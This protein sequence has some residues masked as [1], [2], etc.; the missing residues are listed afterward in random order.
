MSHQPLK[1]M[2]LCLFLVCYHPSSY[3]Y[4]KYPHTSNTISTSPPPPGQP[5]NPSR[6]RIRHRH[7]GGALHRDGPRIEGSQARRR[8]DHAQQLWQNHIKNDA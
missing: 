2:L 6:P 8:R 4:T 3:C 5:N 1:L 7:R